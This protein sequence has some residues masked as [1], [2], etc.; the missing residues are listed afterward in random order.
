M[1][2]CAELRSVRKYLTLERVNNAENEPAFSD[3]V[4]GVGELA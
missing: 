2:T 1:E 4:D 3:V